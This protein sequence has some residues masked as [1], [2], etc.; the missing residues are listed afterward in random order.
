MNNICIC[1]CGL[2]RSL[3]L[4]IEKFNKIFNGYNIDYILVLSKS[5]DKEYINNINNEIQNPKIIK[6]LIIK[7]Y[8]YNDFR[9]SENYSNKIIHSIKLIQQKYDLYI[10][11]RS[12]L[13]IDSINLDMFDNNNLYFCN[14][15]LN[16]YSYNF[17]RIND[18]I[19]I[20]KDYNKILQLLELHEYNQ[21]NKNYLDINLY[22]YLK[23]KKIN[24]E[25]VDF[26][27]KLILSECNII[28]INGDSGSGKTTLSKILN[29][30]FEKEVCILETDRYHKWERGNENYQQYTHLNPYAN[31]LER[32]S[33]DVFQ[34]KIGEDVYQIDYDHSSGKFTQKEKIENK[35]NL[36]LCGLHTL[37]QNNM[38]KLLNLKIYL[39]TDRELIKKWKIQRDI[40][41]RGHSLEKV[42]NQL[43]AREKDYNE[44]IIQQKENADIIIQFYEVS[45]NLECNFIISNE[46]ISYK[47]IKKIINLNYELN[48]ENNKLIIK[49]NNID[50]LNQDIPPLINENINLFKNKYYKELFFLIKIILIYIINE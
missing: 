33:E 30:L 9:N 24:Y 38:N 20:T 21:M 18:N 13:I 40:K 23:E 44:Y 6:N 7:D 14:N 32:L 34:Y 42:L 27:Y 31:H 16:P 29:L 3:S 46:D 8:N 45:G 4:V 37:Y 19:M 48:Y 36:I 1:I 47:I 11:C 5:T 43:E 10:L 49:L 2:N 12:D 41:E 35:K 39:D 17:N 25:L 50:E 15:H 28:A 22:K 26:Q